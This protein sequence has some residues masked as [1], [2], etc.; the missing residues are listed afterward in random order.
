MPCILLLF[1][2]WLAVFPERNS[3]QKGPSNRKADIDVLDV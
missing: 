3:T 1:C 2:K